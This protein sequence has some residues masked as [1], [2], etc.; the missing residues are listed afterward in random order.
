GRADRRLTEIAEAHV[1]DDA[2]LET[3]FAAADPRRLRP[4]R[5]LRYVALDERM[6]RD[7]LDVRNDADERLGTLD[8]L[9]VGA[10]SGAPRYIV[11]DADGLFSWRR[12]LLP[13]TIVRFDR[14]AHLLR[15][16]LDKDIASRCP[17]FDRDEFDRM[18]DEAVREY[19]ARLLGFFPKEDAAVSVPKHG[20]E[21]L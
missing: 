21:A 8:G 2:R 5:P 12:S 13:M 6:S 20:D 4:L 3:D 14:S 16:A 18:D 9:G 19:E 11:V 1:N 7:S 17:A 15:V 10:T